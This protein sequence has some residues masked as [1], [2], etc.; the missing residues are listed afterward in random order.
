MDQRAQPAAAGAVVRRRRP[1]PL[2]DRCTCGPGLRRGL[3]VDVRSS[4]CVMIVCVAEASQRAGDGS[5]GFLAGAHRCGAGPYLN[6][7]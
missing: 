2:P 4:S 6:G 7:D 5:C 3:A 1:G